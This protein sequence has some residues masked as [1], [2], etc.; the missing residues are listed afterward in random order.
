VTEAP[1]DTD[2]PARDP[3][4]TARSAAAVVLAGGVSKRMRSRLVKVLHPLAGR[5]V[6]AH[7]MAP[8]R[9]LGIDRTLVVV[10]HQRERVEEALRAPGVEFVLQEEPLGTGHALLQ[11]RPR[12]EDFEGDLLVT[13][14]DTPLLREATLRRLLE[15]HRRSGAAATVLTAVVPDPS[16]YGRIVRDAEG[17]LEGIVE[18][19][20]ASAEI[21]RISEIN[22]GVYCFR[23]AEALPLL[24]RVANRN[25]QGEYYLTDLPPLLARAPGGV[26]AVAVE[27]P[28]EV[29]G[30]N[31]REQLAAAEAVLRARIRKRAMAAGVTMLQ[32]ETVL[33]DDQVSIGPDSVLYPGV[34]VEGASAIGPECVIGPWSRIVESHVGRGV[35]LK[36]WNFVARTSI[37]PG[38]ILGPYV[39]K[40]ND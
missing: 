28:Q 1:A 21:R 32:P 37:P 36:G 13:A 8:L 2:A 17:R 15:H 29:L 19:R 38:A 39:R 24:D 5:P 18:E 6:I 9:A 22:T 3:A 10:G 7:V 26:Q 23:A 25:R 27:D 34:I 14:G 40:G 11:C 30:I 16:G 12:L 35:E 4:A 31:D 20:D 33:L